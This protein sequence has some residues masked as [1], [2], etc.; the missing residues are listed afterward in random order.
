M[1]LIDLLGQVDH[2]YL[3]S[4]GFALGKTDIIFTPETFILLTGDGSETE[5]HFRE[6]SLP[7]TNRFVREYFNSIKPK[8]RPPDWDYTG[9]ST[10]IKPE[11]YLDLITM[12]H[13]FLGSTTLPL[14][15]FI[16]HSL[17]E[18][19][20][21]VNAPNY[22]AQLTYS[23]N[24][25]TEFTIDRTLLM[26]RTEDSNE[27]VKQLQQLQEYLRTNTLLATLAYSIPTENTKTLFSIRYK[28]EEEPDIIDL[29]N[30][31]CSTFPT[32]KP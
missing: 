4:G 19:I 16:P 11:D 31:Y 25:I 21:N 1:S 28:N 22:L 6:A 5:K 26:C 9:F 15:L 23:P 24:N 20:E 27:T 7:R 13:Y 10:K 2:K 18:I 14:P 17:L 3:K 30:H 8:K 12:V 29:I 32:S